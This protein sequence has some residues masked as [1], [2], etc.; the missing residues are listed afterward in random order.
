MLYRL[1]YMGIWRPKPQW[2]TSNSVFFLV[3]PKE[4][5]DDAGR[6]FYVIKKRFASSP[7]SERNGKP[8]G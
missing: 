8:S 3:F 2:C 7:N 5:G 4:K 1:S 6:I